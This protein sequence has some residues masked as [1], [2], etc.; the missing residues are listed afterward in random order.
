MADKVIKAIEGRQE[1]LERALPGLSK[2]IAAFS[3]G[4]IHIKR[5]HGENY[6]Y[7]VQDGKNEVLLKNDDPMISELVQKDYLEKALR[8]VNNELLALGRM[9]KIYPDDVVEDEYGKISEAR[10]EFVKPLIL[11]DE[12]YIQ[13]WLDIPFVPKTIN[14]DLPVFLTLKGERVRSKSEMIIADRLYMKEIPYKYE[15]PLILGKKTIHPDFSVL[16]TS[17]R[18]VIYYEHCGMMGKP[19]YV[20]DLVSRVNDYNVAGYVLGDSL[21]LTFESAEQPLDVRTLD[22]M[23][24]KVFR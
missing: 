8:S 2:T 15:C 13:R 7:L 3:N 12:Q 22:S 17:E 21:F 16:K 4:K 19:G 14:E 6:Y 24:E 23:I 1:Q 11:N 10:R 18:K 5:I 9:K 20:K